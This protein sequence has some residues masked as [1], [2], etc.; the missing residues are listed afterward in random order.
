MAIALFTLAVT[1]AAAPVSAQSRDSLLNGAAIGAGVGAGLG[2]AF[3]HAVRDSDLTAGQYAYGALI[4]GAIGA[5][6]GLGID[7]LFQR[8]N[9]PRTAAPRRFF[10]APVAWRRVAGASVAWRW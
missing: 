1:L 5:G 6:A 10:F 7:A 9:V 4:F 8:N 2:I 3:T